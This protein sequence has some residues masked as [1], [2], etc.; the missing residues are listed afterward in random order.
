MLNI[1]EIKAFLNTYEDRLVYLESFLAESLQEWTTQS[2][3]NTFSATW[4][5]PAAQYVAFPKPFVNTPE[6]IV[7][8]KTGGNTLK[9]GTPVASDITNKG[10]TLSIP[11]GSSEMNANTKSVTVSW[12]ASEYVWK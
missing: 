11:I 10:F 8:S 7:L 4:S 3:S 2:G 12:S 6:N 9:F 5:S 1:E